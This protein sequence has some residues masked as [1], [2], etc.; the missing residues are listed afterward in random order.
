MAKQKLA[1]WIVFKLFTGAHTL[2]LQQWKWSIVDWE[3]GMIR[4]P[5]E[6]T[7]LKKNAIHYSISEVPNLKE[8]LKWAWEIDGKPAPDKKIAHKSQPTITKHIAKAMN[9][10]KELF[11]Q[12][13]RKKIV[14]MDTH[15]NFMRS[16]FITYGIEIIGVGKVS[17]IA[18]DR[19]NLDKYL[20]FDAATDGGP[21][22][23]KFFGL[24]PSNL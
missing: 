1:G 24:L 12:D 17:K 22:A 13:K 21:E 4:I 6:Q 10:K 2:L 9:Q 15:R 3:K 7:K 23:E 8:W 16:G 5:K 18:E 20:A 14:P 11:I 19:H